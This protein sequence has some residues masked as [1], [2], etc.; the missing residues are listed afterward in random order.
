MLLWSYEMRAAVSLCYDVKVDVNNKR[1]RPLDVALRRGITPI[2]AFLEHIRSN[3]CDKKF[4]RSQ[5]TYDSLQCRGVSR[6]YE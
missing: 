1:E 6:N 4:L 2:V 5:R 3:T